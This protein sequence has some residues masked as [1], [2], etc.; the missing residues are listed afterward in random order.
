LSNHIQRILIAIVGIPLIIILCMAGGIYF[1]TFMAAVSAVALFEFY[2]L[3]VAKGAKPLVILGLL[4]GFMVNMS[5]YHPKLKTFIVGCF[6]SQGI[7]IPFPSQTQLLFI[8]LI[9]ALVILA[10]VEL[11]RNNGSALLNLSTTFFGILY[12][13]VFFGT[14]IGLRELF[15]PFDF[16]MGRYFSAPASYTDP[17]IA[18]QVYRWGGYTVLSVLVMIWICDSAAYY[19][20]RV[21][22][23]HKL[24]PRVSPNKTWEGAFFG[25]I[26]AVIVAIATKYLVL[27]YLSVGSAIVLGVIVGVFGQLGDLIESLLKRDAGVKDSSNLIPGHGGVLDRFDSLLLVSPLVYLYLDFILF[28]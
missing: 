17:L 25:F 2:K 11:F 12:I 19:G 18:A 4:T 10:L 5:F 14:F 7:M 28:S 1:F 13:S 20:G 16:P 23:K 21:V 6:E 9:T 24:F 3:S 27:E 15:V 8:T 26:S 22:G